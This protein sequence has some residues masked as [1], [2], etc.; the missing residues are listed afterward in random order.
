M[1]RERLDLSVILEAQDQ[2]AQ[3]GQLELP[4]LLEQLDLLVQQALPDLQEHQE[5]QRV[6]PLTSI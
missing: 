2:L 1:Q 5:S 4:E 6:E 3:L